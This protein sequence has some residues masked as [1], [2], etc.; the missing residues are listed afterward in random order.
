MISCEL[1][2][3]MLTCLNIDNFQSLPTTHNLFLYMN[4]MPNRASQKQFNSKKQGLVTDFSC[5][6]IKENVEIKDEINCC[7]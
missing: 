5:K 2:I 7:F 4:A 3:G 6:I 1:W